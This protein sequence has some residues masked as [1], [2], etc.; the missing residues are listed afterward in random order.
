VKRRLIVT[1]DDFGMSQEVNE[2]VEIAHRQGVLTCASLVVAGGA[3]DDA[4]R[5]ARR[6]P[7]LG[8]GL[9]LALFGA[10]ARSSAQT[11]SLIAPDGRNLGE[12]PVRAGS[13][14]MLSKRVREAARSEIQAQFEAYRLSGLDLDHLDGHWH[15]HQHPAVLAMALEIGKP[16]GLR[17]VR[18]PYE[19][20][21]FSRRI[22][23]R[24]MGAS[25]LFAA[26]AHYPL[27]LNIRRT[28]RTARLVAND[29]FFGKNDAG[30]VTEELLLRLVDHLPPGTTEV[31][32]HPSI[33]RW[34]G[35]HAPPADWEP[36]QELSALTSPELGKAIVA[37]GIE[38]CRWADLP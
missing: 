38:L 26:I 17:A 4:I 23:A 5:R 10:P 21:G 28:I 2:A 30:F 33:R 1:A 37:A 20:Y 14:I 12:S 8:V 36:E 13:A 19:P 7:K 34:S 25:R 3:A 16:L 9:H 18:I 15:C 35:R 32:L 31:G 27:A 22:A 24:G 11:P 6:M 29:Q